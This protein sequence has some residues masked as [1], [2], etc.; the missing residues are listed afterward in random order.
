MNQTAHFP[1]PLV[2]LGGKDQRPA[3]LPDDVSDKHALS[4]YKGMAIRIN[5]RPI[6]EVIIERIN[7]CGMFG[8]I[9]IAGP[10]NVYQPVSD[11]AHIIDTD[12]K[13]DENVDAAL[14]SISLL[15]PNGPVA[16]FACDVLPDPETLKQLTELY[17]Q[18]GHS[19]IFFP[20]IKVPEQTE[21]LGSSGWK[22]KYQVI[23]TG[24]TQPTTVL[25]SHLLII[26]PKALRL[27][28]IFTLTRLAY[29]TRNRGIEQ[30]KSTMIRGALWFLIKE[31]LKQL[32]KF[33]LPHLTTTVLSNAIAGARELASGSIAQ[34]T[35]ERRLRK[36][37]I[38]ARR[39]VRHRRP[40]VYLPVVD[41][42]ELAKDIDTLEEVE[43]LGAELTAD[44]VSAS[45][46]KDP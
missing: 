25:P 2:I 18:S 13:L 26:N 39:R 3:K 41:A 31:D 21:Q 34:H 42:L 24:D 15:H 14:Q 16:F 28:L 27:R 4:A 33:K 17:R 20:L 8:P 5:N 12:G 23:P 45:P 44:E 40:L 30:R 11:L 9:Y 35:L 7:A 38:K 1:I 37:L 6:I 19:D 29:Q 22:P 36:I 32:A 46:S 43:E 10:M